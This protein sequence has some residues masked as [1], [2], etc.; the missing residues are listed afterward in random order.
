M[1][2]TDLTVARRVRALVGDDASIDTA[3]DGALRVAP[4]TTAGCALLLQSA[5]TEGWTI[6]LAGHGSFGHDDA[7]AHIV[8]SSKNLS[9]VESVRGP[10]LVATVQAGVGRRMLNRTLAD[11]GVWWPVDAPGTNRT[12]GSMVATATAGPLRSGFGTARDHVLGLT[13]ITPDGRIIRCGGRVVKNVAGF[14]LTKLATGSFGAFGFVTDVHLRLRAIPRADVTLLTDGDRDELLDRAGALIE[15]GL[16]PS[17]LE[18][19]SPTV[20]D[21][22]RWTL[23]ARIVGSEASVASDRAALVGADPGATWTDVQPGEAAGLWEQLVAAG[24]VHPLTVRLGTVVSGLREALDLV[25]HHLDDEVVT[26][27]VSAGAIR[28]S[29]SA[30]LDHLRLFRHAAA[31]REMPVTIERAPWPLLHEIGHFGAY[32]EGV[33]RLMGA[34]RSTFDPHGTLVVP[35]GGLS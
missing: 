6:R 33:N 14:D 17:A 5:A 10:D 11:H 3:A 22:P 34:L 4:R 26:V 32:R 16:I 35:L 29:G 15:S 19:V 21:R 1:S 24:D 2:D 27:T 8:L 12:V 30:H 31:Q 13:I 23:A 9:A 25:S 7:P 20:A 28:W 18:L